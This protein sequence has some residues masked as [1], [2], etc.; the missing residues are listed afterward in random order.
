MAW[1][2]KYKLTSFD[3]QPIPGLLFLDGDL[4][5]RTQEPDLPRDWAREFRGL[6]YPV[7]IFPSGSEA[8]L[9]TDE[10]GH[11]LVGIHRQMQLPY[12]DDRESAYTHAEALVEEHQK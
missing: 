12:Y 3:T 5:A 7:V 8:S 2:E 1:T 4:I 6:K 10:A 11:V 9:I